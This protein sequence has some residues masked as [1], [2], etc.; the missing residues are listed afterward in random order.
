[1]SRSG[2]F[3]R[4]MDRIADDDAWSRTFLGVVVAVIVIVAVWIAT[5]IVWFDR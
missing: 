3:G 5:G 1:M 4:L 2:W